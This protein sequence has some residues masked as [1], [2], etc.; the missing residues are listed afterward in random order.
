ADI[1]SVVNFGSNPQ[2][3]FEAL[4]K[5]Q[6]TGPLMC[7]EFYPA[8]FDHWSNSHQTKAVEEILPPL[9]YMLN[10]GASF[11]LYMVH[12]GT[13]FGFTAGANYAD[14]FKPQTT[15]YDY[16]APISEAGWETPK[17]HVLRELFVNHLNPGETIPD[18]PARKPVISIPEIRFN[19]SAALFDFPGRNVKSKQ[20]KPLE[21]YGQNQGCV[22]YSTTLPQGE[23]GMLKFAALNDFAHIYLDSKRIATYDRHAQTGR[24]VTGFNE[25]GQNIVVSA[26]P[27]E[28]RISFLVPARKKA[29]RL[30]VF[31]ESMGHINYG[32]VIDTDRKGILGSVVLESDGK[33]REITQWKAALFPLKKE[34]LS[35]I[36]FTNK[37]TD[38]P[39]FYRQTFQLKETGDTFLDMRNWKKGVVW[40]NGH[41]LGRYW[42]VGPSRT[43][44]LPGPWLKEGENEIVV[45]ELQGTDEPSV[46]GLSTPI[47]DQ[48]G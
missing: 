42:H 33:A 16:D 9:E 24:W 47:L 18:I 25:K 45:L 6:E 34:Q 27:V 29:A 48:P 46:T 37:Q 13:S 30:E 5:L 10:H 32:A 41:N 35:G 4:R 44:Y 43:L 40:V 15:S 39:A 28:H 23:A 2:A 26:D 11:S 3:G 7:G 31:I 8:W 19:Q 12:G 1:F 36:K 21:L 22:L 20:P 38:L 14:R 17:F